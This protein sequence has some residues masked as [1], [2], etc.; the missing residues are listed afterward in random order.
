MMKMLSYFAVT[1]SLVLS[2]L[3]HTPG[4]PDEISRRVTEYLKDTNESRILD[5]DEGHRIGA[6]TGPAE[7]M[8]TTPTSLRVMLSSSSPDAFSLRIA[9]VNKE[10]IPSKKTGKKSSGPRVFKTYKAWSAFLDS[11][12]TKD[13]LIRQFGKPLSESKNPESITFEVSIIKGEKPTRFTC[14]ITDGRLTHTVLHD[15]DG[16]SR[17]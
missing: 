15:G 10:Q 12:P 14:Y 6:R 1:L 17:K 5:E 13:A 16:G 7:N 11:K 3:G 2:A 9:S 8:A 4:A